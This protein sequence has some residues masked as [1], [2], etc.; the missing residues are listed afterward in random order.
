MQS[1]VPHSVLAAAV[2]PRV[3]PISVLRISRP[4]NP[5]LKGHSKHKDTCEHQLYAVAGSWTPRM[6]QLLGEIFLFTFTLEI[7][8]QF[9]PLLIL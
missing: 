3:P 7:N 6:G 1:P 4:S 2:C 9:V 8:H 5:K